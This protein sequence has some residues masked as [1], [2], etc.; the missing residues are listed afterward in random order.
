MKTVFCFVCLTFTA[1]VLAQ[2]FGYSYYRIADYRSL[3]IS[4]NIQEFYPTP[5]RS[6]HDS[7]LIRFTTNMPT[8][9][10]RELNARVS[11]GY[12][13]YSLRG[14]SLTAF[15]VYMESGNDFAVTGKDQRSGFFIP[16][17]LSANYVRAENP[18]AGT[19]NFDIGSLG[20][21]GGAKYR[22]MTRDFGLQI[23]VTGTLHYASVGFG[24]EYGS[25]T[26]VQSELQFILPGLLFDGMVFGYRYEQQRWNMSDAI[27]DYERWYHGPFVG[28]FF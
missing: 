5:N 6:I 4:Y 14:R 9:E 11:V 12:Q 16:V 26:S 24:T 3:G 21:G 2:D 7:L 8:I 23:F 18:S 22:F 10:Y 25:Q 28:I 20:L 27:F 19:K 13:S 17:K 1:P 15:S